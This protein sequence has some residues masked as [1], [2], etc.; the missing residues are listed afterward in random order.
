MSFA[1]VTVVIGACE[2]DSGVKETISPRNGLVRVSVWVYEEA[3]GGRAC[4]PHEVRPKVQLDKPTEEEARSPDRRAA[5]KEDIIMFAVI[6]ALPVAAEEA[7]PGAVT[8]TVAAP[9][10]SGERVE[11]Q[12]ELNVPVILGE[13]GA[14]RLESVVKVLYVSLR[15]SQ[16]EVAKL[17]TE[18]RIL[19]LVVPLRVDDVLIDLASTNGGI[20]VHPFRRGES[21]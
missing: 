19:I 21:G 12:A 13:A 5:S 4:R 18:V 14:Q 7:G 11:R 9:A 2:P 6:R 15:A 20:R 17:A 1:E 16:I 10:I 8:A 3:S